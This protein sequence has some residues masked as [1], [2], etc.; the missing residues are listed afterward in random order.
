MKLASF[1]TSDGR[2]GAGV[3]TEEG[4]R[5]LELEPASPDFMGFSPM[6]RILAQ[7]GT[8]LTALGAKA[9]T[10]ELFGLDAITLDA[11]VPDPGKIVAAPVNYR[12][13][14]AE[15]NQDAH[16]DALGFFLKSPSSVLGPGGTVQLPYTDRRFDQ[17]GELAIIIGTAASHISVQDAPSIIAGYTLLLDMTMRG[18]EDRSTRKSFDTFTPMGPYLVTPD[19]I[20]NLD[21][22]SLQCS[23]D[24][25]LRQDADISDLIWGVPELIAYASSV[26]KLLPGDVITTGTPA[27]IGQVA[28]GQRIALEVSRLGKLEVIVSADGAV[29]CPTRGANRGPKP[30]ETITP[31]RQTPSYSK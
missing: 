2:R 11:P 3:V 28:D 23:V 12:D 21:Q 29:S 15:M 7:Y 5:A 17:E 30:P 1:T 16:I 22:L 9:A 8:E 25:T 4:I 14:Q 13:H 10:G 6:R 18:G 27:G 31:V 24:G 19:E 20:G 26:T